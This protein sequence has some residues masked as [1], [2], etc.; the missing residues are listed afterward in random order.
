MVIFG[1]T[2]QPLPIKM[3]GHA[4]HRW[5]RI[6]LINT[7]ILLTH[8][9]QKWH[10]PCFLFT[11]AYIW[12]AKIHNV[13]INF[14]TGKSPHFFRFLLL[15]RNNVSESKNN[16]YLNCTLHTPKQAFLVQEM[17][18]PTHEDYKHIVY[19]LGSVVDTTGGRIRTFQTYDRTIGKQFSLKIDGQR[20]CF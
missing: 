6:N 9:F 1:G 14:L 3:R 8:F 20:L 18:S 11:H 19:M 17:G 16:V 4:M 15:S 5:N 10:K 2:L 12:Y 7:K 13:T